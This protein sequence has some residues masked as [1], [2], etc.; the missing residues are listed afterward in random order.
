MSNFLKTCLASFSLSTECLIS[1]LQPE[2][3]SEGVEGQQM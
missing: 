3:L 1:A 2:L